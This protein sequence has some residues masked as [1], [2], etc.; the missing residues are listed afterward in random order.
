VC[1]PPVGWIG[2]ER[3]R[4][5]P[6]HGRTAGRRSLAAGGEPTTV[7]LPAL[8]PRHIYQEPLHDQRELALTLVLLRVVITSSPVLLPG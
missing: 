2:A 5:R 8:V 1:G 3:Y 4:A 7:V 6:R